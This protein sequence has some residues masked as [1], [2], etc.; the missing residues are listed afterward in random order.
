LRGRILQI[1][2]AVA[3]LP[4]INTQFMAITYPSFPLV[5]HC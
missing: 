1:C 4:R 5:L 2:S 3:S